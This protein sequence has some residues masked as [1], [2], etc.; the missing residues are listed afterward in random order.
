MFELIVYLL[1]SSILFATLVNR[2][3]E[4]PGE[5]ERAN[6]TAILAQMRTGV[7]LQMMD[8]IAS[9]DFGR[10]EELAGSNP[11]DLMLQPPS[12]YVGSFASV[13]INTMPRRVWYF[14]RSRGEL[15]YLAD[16]SQNLYVERNGASQ[17]DAH[18]RFRITNVQA[19]DA[20]AGQGWQGLTLAPVEPYQWRRVPIDIQ[21]IAES[22]T[23]PDGG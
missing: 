4:F 13:D 23:Q 1:V 14:D 9:A 6:F 20:P 7:N 11:M 21:A 19:A 18:I 2:Y 12:N 17:P 22:N 10:G 5:A 15:V 16:D 3:R 8:M